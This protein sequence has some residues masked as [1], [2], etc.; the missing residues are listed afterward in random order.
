MPRSRYDPERDYYAILGVPAGASA[1][2][3]QRAYRRLAKECHPDRNPDRL[4]WATTTFQRVNEAY[5]ILGDPARRH[6]YDDLRWPHVRHTAA[7]GSPLDGERGRY[8]QP[9]WTYA[10]WAR[11][12]SPPPP[13]PEFSRAGPLA[14]LKALLRGPFGSIYLILMLVC[15]TMPVTTLV[16]NNWLG[17]AAIQ[18]SRVCADPRAQIAFPADDEDIPATF[19]VRGTAIGAYRVEWAYLGAAEDPRD[20]VWRLVGGSTGGLVTG[21]LLAQVRLPEDALPGLYA[22]RLVVTGED[23]RTLTPCE[24]RVTYRGGA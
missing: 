18:P 3:I 20:P 19:S 24:R 1:A 6:D 5:N 2:E 8:E 9:T 23:G 10:D 14:P 12:A 16:V 11:R 13:S 4:D 22:L 15:L 7:R 21:D 17:R